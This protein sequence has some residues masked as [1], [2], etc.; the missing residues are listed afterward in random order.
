MWV[1]ARRSLPWLA[2]LT[3]A[4][5][6]LP[7]GPWFPN[8]ILTGGDAVVLETPGVDFRVEVAAVAAEYAAR[9]SAAGPVNPAIG[10]VEQDLADVQAALEHVPLPAG[11]AERLL[12]A[13]RCLRG[14]GEDAAAAGVQLEGTSALPRE[15][16]LYGEG[17]TA[18]HAGDLP[19]ARARWRELLDLPAPQ[20]RQRSVW[21]AYMLGRSQ[22]EE[23]APARQVDPYTSTPAEYVW[24][25]AAEA[26]SRFACAR[27]LAGEG[28][29]DPLGLAHQ[30]LGWEAN[31]EL[32]SGSAARAVELYVEQL[33]AGD[34]TVASSLR[35]AV[36]AALRSGHGLDRLV[37]DPGCRRVVT[38]ALLASCQRWFAGDQ[39]AA[40]ATAA[41][42]TWLTAVEAE[43]AA[44]V[45]GADRLAW[46]AYQVNDL[47]SC[48]RW[49]DRAGTRSL[50]TR[51]LHAKLL[52]HDGSVDEGT[53]ALAA[54]AGELP[55]P[56]GWGDL[57]AARS[58][59]YPL[60]EVPSPWR[61][62]VYYQEQWDEPA[63]EQWVL[64]ELG[65]LE[66]ARGDY[67]GSL[68]ALLRGGFWLDAAYVAERVL[69]TAELRR[70][71]DERWP[72]AC[73]PSGLPPFWETHP[74]QV[75]GDRGPLL[76]FL[77]AR[78]LVREHRRDDATAYMPGNLQSPLAELSTG[79]AAGGR[80]EEAAGDRAR[81]LYGAATVLRDDGEYLAATE[82]DPDWLGLYQCNFE[83]T[84]TDTLRA[85]AGAE[86]LTRAGAQEL[87]LAARTRASPY[88][89][90]HYRYLAADLA[91]RAAGLLPDG[92]DE[93][94][95][96]LCTAGSW[97][98]SRDPEAAER[99]YRALVRRCP[100]TELGRRA[101]GLRWF[102]PC[103]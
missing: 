72:Q 71:V 24:K 83:M 98:K 45:E 37:R 16:L 35:W 46:L 19:A 58:T 96:I 59:V 86:P 13:Y 30:S 78:R 61:G 41:S 31:L 85:G 90:F 20:R 60:L 95:G 29:L 27:E 50:L 9:A 79:L 66:L 49:L 28:F 70:Y 63:V 48:R 6:A 87:A 52:L 39:S 40:G 26:R 53:R 2:A 32:T 5:P 18:Y 11:E 65:S 93:L 77:L 34:V 88:Q 84:A 25:D 14:G 33:E 74:E 75:C 81:A 12:A 21:A 36:A 10:T 94:A 67:V 80:A 62:V 99:F 54:L 44:G 7:C 103:E 100:E 92:G 23:T 56:G 57:A 68:D 38:A 76:R 91:W 4:A 47:G 102:P 22:R 3:L 97:L 17:A 43:G 89:R 101:A 73:T 64:G 42:A 69:S 8:R 82:L 1:R 55:G 15:L 51:W